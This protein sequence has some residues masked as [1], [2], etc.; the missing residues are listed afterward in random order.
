MFKEF[1][2]F[3]SRGN[4]VELAVGLIMG[5]YFGAIV[6]SLVDDVIMPPIGQ[7]IAG[8]D[9]AGL[10]YTLGTKTLQDGTVQE[11][12][13]NYGIFLNN[14]LTFLIV[15][16]AVFLVVHAYNNFL[17]KKKEQPAAAEKAPTSQEQLLMEIRDA[18]REKKSEV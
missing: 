1:K 5:T 3:V 6:K 4:V 10:K 14:I 12:A 11:V 16:F 13:V 18:I 8:V 9:F 2:E 17:R 7:L 15:S